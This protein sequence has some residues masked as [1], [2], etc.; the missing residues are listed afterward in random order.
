M[1]RFHPQFQGLIDLFKRQANTY[2]LQWTDPLARAQSAERPVLVTDD[3]DFNAAVL[4]GADGFANY[5]VT[6]GALAAVS[7]IAFT[8]GATE[9]FVPELA[10]IGKSLQTLI[11]RDSTHFLNYSKLAASLP[12]IPLRVIIEEDRRRDAIG[13]LIFE[14]GLRFLMIH[15]QMHFVRGHLHY[16]YGVDRPQEYDEIP[17]SPISSIE[18]LDR[19]ALELDADGSALFFLLALCEDNGHLDLLRSQSGGAREVIALFADYFGWARL[20][21]LG[22]LTV[23]MLM[24]LSDRE[25]ATHPLIETRMLN[26]LMTHEEFVRSKVDFRTLDGPP[27]SIINFFGDIAAVAKILLVS[28][29][30]AEAFHEKKN[31]R[32]SEWKHFACVELRD[33]HERLCEIVPHLR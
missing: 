4:R 21:G 7:D 1:G 25:N 26:L 24:S 16:L 12:L 20:V 6:A 32:E 30:D 14:V 19:K 11:I 17:A 31:V 33:L 10:L 8:A 3:L 9:E 18:S 5:T 29:P 28:P 13:N 22:A 15:E 2:L 23:M 27:S